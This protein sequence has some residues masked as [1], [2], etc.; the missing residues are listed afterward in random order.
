MSF[1][2]KCK[3]I[4]FSWYSVI[5]CSIFIVLLSVLPVKIPEEI[6]FPFFDKV[7]HSI[8]YIALSFLA[9]NTL[10]FKNKKNHKLT[11][12]LYAF[13]LGLVIEI[14]QYFLPYRDYQLSDVAFNFLGSYIGSL[15]VFV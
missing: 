7:A 2:D 4:V 13:S 11:G 9:T 15:I 5:V 14:I 10:N 3:V 8:M 6:S 1:V 12:I